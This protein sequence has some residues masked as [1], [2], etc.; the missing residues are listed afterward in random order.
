MYMCDWVYSTSD[1]SRDSFLLFSI[2]GSELLIKKEHTS[3]DVL[4]LTEIM[5][6]NYFKTDG[7]TCFDY[8][9]FPL[10]LSLDENI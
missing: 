10:L 7:L 8:Y 2:V 9:L 6:A 1:K 4:I 3:G 5:A